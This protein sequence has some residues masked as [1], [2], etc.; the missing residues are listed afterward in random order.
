MPTRRARRHRFLVSAFDHATGMVA[1]QVGIGSK[2]SEITAARTLLDLLDLKG[3]LYKVT[4]TRRRLR[5]ATA[6]AAQAG[7]GRAS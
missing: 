2:D 7:S 6:Q 4:R 3:T 5:P 1:A